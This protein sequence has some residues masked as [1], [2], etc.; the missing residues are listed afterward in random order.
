MDLT[1]SI[2][3][4]DL[5]SFS[6]PYE[7]LLGDRRLSQGFQACVWGIISSGS[8]KVSQIAASNPITGRT[9]HGERRLRRLLHGGNKRAEVSAEMLSRV[10]SETG[11]KQL[12]GEHE[13]L[14]I[15]DESDL[16][17]PFASELEHLDTV[18]DLEG[19][20]VPGFHT[21]TVLGIG[22][23]GKRALLY[24]TSFSW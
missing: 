17:K 4:S 18:R 6:E 13:V 5:A 1:N 16:R 9:K 8:C 12:K 19:N 21:L 11:A 3:S 2:K 10:L 22:E 20:P 14:L 15:I 7:R 24:Q 23:S